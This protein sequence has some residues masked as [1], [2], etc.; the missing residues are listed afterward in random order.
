[1]ARADAILDAATA[2]LVRHPRIA[3]ALICASIL[4]VFAL[5]APQ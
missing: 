5:D 3:C 2:W 1:M 4:I